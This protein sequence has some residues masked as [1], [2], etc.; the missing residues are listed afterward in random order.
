MAKVQT[1]ST[2]PA[3]RIA[4]SHGIYEEEV[5]QAHECQNYSYGYNPRVHIAFASGG[6][7]WGSANSPTAHD[8]EFPE[9]ATF[10]TYYDFRTYVDPDTVQILITLTATFTTTMDGEARITIGA[11][12]T[13]LAFTAGT[14]STQ[15]ATLNTSSTGTGVVSCLIE[16]RQTVSPY[17]PGQSLDF[18]SIQDQPVTS[19]LPDPTNT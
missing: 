15:T 12:N 17:N 19:S 10:T 13:T 3:Y 4:L 14:T 7:G 11:T 6:A 1:A 9:S 5:G 2:I 18:V 8:V 16:L